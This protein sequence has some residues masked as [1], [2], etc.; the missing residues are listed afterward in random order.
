[1]IT[2]IK[3]LSLP[4]L[5]IGFGMLSLLALWLIMRGMEWLDDVIK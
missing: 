2:I 4:L 3:C 5:I 1:M